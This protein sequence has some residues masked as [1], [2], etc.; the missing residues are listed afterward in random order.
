[1]APDRANLHSASRMRA[2][3]RRCHA[4]GMDR[5]SIGT[6]HPCQRAL[7]RIDQ[8]PR[9]KRILRLRPAA[10]HVFDVRP[11]GY[12]N[13]ANVTLEQGKKIAPGAG[14]PAGRPIPAI[15]PA[16]CVRPAVPAQGNMRP[17]AAGPCISCVG[18]PLARLEIARSA[19]R[20]AFWNHAADLQL[21]EARALANHYHFHKAAER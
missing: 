17:L 2:T 18:A 19:L 10:W 15:R 8:M 12:R 3:R 21:A 6:Q 13:G 20:S 7:H 14:G 16:R 1:M 4:L 5:L 11:R 9:S